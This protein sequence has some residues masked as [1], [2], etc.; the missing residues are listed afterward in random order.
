VTGESGAATPPGFRRVSESVAGTVSGSRPHAIPALPRSGTYTRTANRIVDEATHCWLCGGGP[1]PDDPFVAD[2]VLPR[3]YGG[4]DTA[5]NLR[6]A[7]RSC[8]GR[9]GA[10][11]GNEG[12]WS[13]GVG[14]RPKIVNRGPE[15][16]YPASFREKNRL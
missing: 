2:D 11:L 3:A 9:R 10:Q 14:G 13:R 15:C 4:A 7:H 5:D 1:R 12:A 6:P 16:G 8:N